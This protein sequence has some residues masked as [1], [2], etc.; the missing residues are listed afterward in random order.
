MSRVLSIDYGLKRVGLAV[1][2][3]L[4][5]IVSGLAT[6]EANELLEYLD[7]YLGK[8]EVEKIVIGWPQHKDGNLTYLSVPILKLIKKLNKKYPLLPILKVDEAFSSQRAKEIIFLS[9]A[10]K[11]KR[12]DKSLVDKI[13]AVVILQQY[14]KHI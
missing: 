7:D 5:I 13:S 3:P 1:T 10:K 2:D 8:E 6:V 11:S 14:L 4:Q 9:G 12:R